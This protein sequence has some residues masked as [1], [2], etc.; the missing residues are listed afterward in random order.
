MPYDL[1]PRNNNPGAPLGTPGSQIEQGFGAPSTE[2]MRE[3]WE[4]AHLLRTDGKKSKSYVDA[5]IR[6]MTGASSLE[7]LSALAFPAEQAVPDE[8]PTIAETAGTQVGRGATLGA[9]P[10]LAGISN[11]LEG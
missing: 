3:V 11:A 7:T 2:R 6:R 4:N 9:L 10:K 1:M 8:S 5:Y